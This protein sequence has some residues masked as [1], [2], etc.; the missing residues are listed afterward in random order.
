MDI[1]NEK[2]T[3]PED[4]VNWIIIIFIVSIGLT[5]GIIGGN[6]PYIISMSISIAIAGI[7]YKLDIFI[8]LIKSELMRFVI[9]ILIT[10]YPALNFI[11]AQKESI[12]IKELSRYQLVTDAISS[13]IILTKTINNSAY[14]SS[15]ADY[16]FF[17]KSSKV[18]IVKADKI[19]S[20]TV[21]EV[22]RKLQ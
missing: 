5:A 18:Y 16:I 8:N 15:T 9:L 20:F 2:D 22:K 21:T 13:D 1:S 10:T 6:H 19:I 3:I 4:L 11:F 14:L 12:A 7:L 17:Y